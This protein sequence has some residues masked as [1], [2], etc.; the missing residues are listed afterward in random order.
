MTTTANET[1]NVRNAWDVE[2]NALIGE[3]T[4]RLSDYK[5]T[6]ILVVNTASKCGFTGQ[7][8][9]LETLYQTY[10]DQGFVVVGVPSNDFAKQEPGNADDI[11]RFCK[12]NYG[13]TFPMTEKNKVKGADAHPF[14]LWARNTLGTGSSPKWNFH[15]YLIGRDGK[16]IDYY[17]STTK[18]MS[19]KV[20]A[21]IEKALK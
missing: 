1:I 2:F 12:I 8:D 7:Y 11:A 21:A 3:D 16:L 5:D 4:I 10:K 18:P 9:G 15:K 13:V 14:Y 19:K 6:V 17:F 20:M